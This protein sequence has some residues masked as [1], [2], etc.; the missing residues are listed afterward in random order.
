M[1]SGNLR[2]VITADMYTLG[3][4]SPPKAPSEMSVIKCVAR[5]I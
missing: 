5:Q 1:I 2:W 4:N 3:P